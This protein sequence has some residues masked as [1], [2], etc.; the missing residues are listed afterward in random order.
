MTTIQE[1]HLGTFH[2]R[3]RTLFAELEAG[4][5]SAAI[6]GGAA[7]VLA[8]LGLAGIAQAY[9][10]PIAT[11]AIGATLILEGGVLMARYADLVAELPGERGGMGFGGGVTAEF[12]GGCAGV[13]LGVLA[14]VGVAPH[15]LLSIAALV[16]G[17]ALLFGSGATARLRNIVSS[18]TEHPMAHELAREAT[19]AASGAQAL[20]GLAAV[21]LGILALCH[22]EA[23][24]LTLVAMLIVGG[25]ILLSGS[26]VASWF[27]SGS[28]RRT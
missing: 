26:A 23:L 5:S 13:V 2:E 24:G 1:Q 20:V 9:M 19:L 12:L 11:L 14:L 21:V 10:L 18:G 7:V 3:E 22:I 6:G 25:S 16:F 28:T 27:M 15:V 4:S 8:I 17:A